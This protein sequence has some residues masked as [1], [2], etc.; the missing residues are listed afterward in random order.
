MFHKSKFR[1]SVSK[2]ASKRQFRKGSK[3]PR[4]EFAC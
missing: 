4:L 3:T 2:H 1:K